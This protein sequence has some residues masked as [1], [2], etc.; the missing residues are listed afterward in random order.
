MPNERAEKAGSPQGVN[1]FQRL[2]DEIRQGSLPPGTRLREADLARRLGISRTPVREAIRLLEAD[3]LVVHVPRVGAAVRSLGYAEVMELYEM[4]AVLEGTAARFAARA[5]SEIEIA[6]M[7]ALNAEMAEAGDDWERHYSLNRKFHLTILDAAKNRFLIKSMA[8]LS[9]TLV[10]LGRSTLT[11]AQ[12][13]RTAIEEHARVL[14][15]IRKRDADAA[16]RA[17]R[18]HVE[19]AHRVRM[20]QLRRSDYP[21]E[22]R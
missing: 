12:R 11:E 1:A 21:L 6:E 13:A 20:L 15:A 7:E 16:E 14:N 3:G 4:R 19:A 17:M 8:A 2:L 22:D 9:R 5:A 18:A 10:I